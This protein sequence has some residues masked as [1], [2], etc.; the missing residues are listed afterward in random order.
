MADELRKSYEKFE[1]VLENL[2][3]LVSSSNRRI[4]KML[5]SGIERH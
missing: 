4:M 1:K 3:Y 5:K 2:V